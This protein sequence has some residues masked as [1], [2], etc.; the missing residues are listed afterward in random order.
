M[1]VSGDERLLV[2]VKCGEPWPPAANRCPNCNAFCAW[3]HE[4][5][6]P[7][8]S[9]DVH[10]DGSWT[11]KPVPE[12]LIRN[13]DLQHRIFDLLEKLNETEH[14]DVVWTLVRTPPFT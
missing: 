6:G 2:C 13:V 12:D 3:G 9:W 7:P 1:S 11:P 8:S 14:G 4:L 5:A 10:E